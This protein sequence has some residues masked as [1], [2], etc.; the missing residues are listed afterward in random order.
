[1]KLKELRLTTSK[2][3][4][5]A[6]CRIPLAGKR[7][8]LHPIPLLHPHLRKGVS[9]FL[10]SLSWDLIM[11]LLSPQHIPLGQTWEVSC[12]RILQRKRSQ[13]IKGVY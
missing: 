12:V 5:K 10:L 9:A 4:A 2:G 1:M 3:C 8:P 6:V 7:D 13:Y 11:S